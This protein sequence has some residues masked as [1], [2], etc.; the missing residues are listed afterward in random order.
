MIAK[1]DPFFQ[2]VSALELARFAG[3]PS[4]MRLPVVTQD[5]PRFADV[6]IGILGVPWDGGTTN[7]PGARHGPRQL[8]D[9]STMIRAM[10]SATQVAPFEA[11][12]CADMGDVPPNP[13]DIQDS[14]KRVS[15][16]IRVLKSQNIVP[17]TAG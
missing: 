2:P 17:M 10:N 15:E 5:H 12:N 3:V 8:R 14:L 1:N 11:V 13:V 6:D 7:R 9:L 4:F 16:F